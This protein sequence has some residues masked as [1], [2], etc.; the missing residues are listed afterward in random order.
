MNKFMCMLPCICY[1]FKCQCAE[2]TK[3]QTLVGAYTAHVEI[4]L[5]CLFIVAGCKKSSVFF[6]NT[7]NVSFGL[8]TLINFKS[9]T[10][11]F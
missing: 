11:V 10:V 8:V 1:H 7:W 6:F 5:F 2:K 9:T 4:C 3:F